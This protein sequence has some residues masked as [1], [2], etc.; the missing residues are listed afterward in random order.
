MPSQSKPASRPPLE[1]SK[2]R[3]L[4]IVTHFQH[5]FHTHRGTKK[6]EHLSQNGASGPPKSEKRKKDHSKKIHTNKK[7]HCRE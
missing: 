6:R 1:E 2:P 4:T 3:K 7:Q 5:F